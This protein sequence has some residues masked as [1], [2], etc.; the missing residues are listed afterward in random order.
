MKIF[1][2]QS[3]DCQLQLCLMA[4]FNFDNEPTCKML[5]HCNKHKQLSWFWIKQLKNLHV[6]TLLKVRFYF[7]KE[8]TYNVIMDLPPW[9][10]CA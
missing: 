2:L 8:E 1:L 3:S 5:I 4:A 6:F 9:L 7:E 10:D